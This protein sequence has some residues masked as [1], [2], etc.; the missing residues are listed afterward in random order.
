MNQ[1]PIDRETAFR[2]SIIKT[3]LALRFPE[4][5][6]EI[7]RSDPQAFGFRLGSGTECYNLQVPRIA[8]SAHG[9]EELRARL[10]RGD[11]G[12]KL[13]E[14]PDGRLFWSPPL[15]ASGFSHSVAR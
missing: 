3:Y 14:A 2:V 11:V 10:H 12:G 8:I 13:Q 15:P 5:D 7:E 4:H 9:P 6:I 1:V